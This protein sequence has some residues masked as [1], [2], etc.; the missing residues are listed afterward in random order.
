VALGTESDADAAF[1]KRIA[2]FGGGQCYF[3]HDPAELPRLF[4]Q[5][6]L[7]IAR[8]TFVDEP[9]AC[10]ALPDLFG[11]GDALGAGQGFPEFGGYN[12]TWLRPDATCGVVTHGEFKSPAFAFAQVGLGR[13][14]AFTGQIGGEFGSALA[15]WEGFS[16]FFVTVVRWLAG[17]EEPAELFA[18]ARRDGRVARIRVEVDPRASIP[19]DTSNLEVRLTGADGTTTVLPL[20]RAGE[21]LFEATATLA[22]EG[23]VLGSVALGDGRSLSLPPLVLPYSPEFEVGADPGRGEALLRQIARESG[24]E[25]APPLGT[26]FR[27]ERRARVWRVVSRECALAALVLLLIEITMRRL[28]LWGALAGIGLALRAFFDRARQGIRRQPRPVVVDQ[29]APSGQPSPAA[30]V[31][32]PA[33][34]STAASR[35]VSAPSSL[36][37]ALSRARRAA[38]RELGR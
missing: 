15:A 5:D 18:S 28:Q 9:V 32:E 14:A 6:T 38:D 11:L 37:D 3:T 12:V 22:R 13:S 17:Q 30:P 8:A 27:G 24:G 33:S 35:N 34:L 23:V 36:D 4:A 16:S 25:V 10:T 20:E 26:L 31:P 29:P 2:E 7:T 21:H 1:L 19:P